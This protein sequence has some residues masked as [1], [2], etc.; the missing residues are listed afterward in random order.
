MA[1]YEDALSALNPYRVRLQEA[2]FA[3]I[4]R[5]PVGML[6]AVSTGGAS[7]AFTTPLTNVHAT[8]VGI[9]VRRGKILPDKFVIKVYVFE[10]LALSVVRVFGTGGGLK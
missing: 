5:Q 8:G 9:R 6:S 4:E 10:K 2:V 1:K 7:S 3:D